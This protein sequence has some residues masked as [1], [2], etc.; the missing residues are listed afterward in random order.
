MSCFL[1]MQLKIFNSAVNVC[2]NMIGCFE[3]VQL[4]PNP[5]II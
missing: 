1:I 5:T 2:S 4:A 3:V